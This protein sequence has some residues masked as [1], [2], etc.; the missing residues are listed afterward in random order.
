MLKDRIVKDNLSK[1][2]KEIANQIKKERERIERIERPTPK[3]ERED[4]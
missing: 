3:K 1:S 4:G 2:F